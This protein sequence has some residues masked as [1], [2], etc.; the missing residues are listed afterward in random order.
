[1]SASINGTK[2]RVR[3]GAIFIYLLSLVLVGSAVAKFAHVPKVALQM[4]SMG[5]DGGKLTLIAVLEIMSA[6]LFL[7][8]RSRS[9]GLLMVSAYLGGA[10]ATHVGHNDPPFQPAIV[11]ALFWIAVWL[12]HPEALTRLAGTAA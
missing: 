11:L 3:L 9:F 5:F 8:P 2:A 10:I 7:V 12:K 1:M 6:I 4:A